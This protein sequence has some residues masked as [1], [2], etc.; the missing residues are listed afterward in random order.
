VMIIVIVDD[1][2]SCR[3]GLGGQLRSLGHEVWLA[4]EVETA[5]QIISAEKVDLVVS[6][7]RPGGR[8]WYEMLSTIDGVTPRPSIA[9]TTAYGSVA[10]AIRSMRLG[11]TAYVTK[12]LCAAT[13]LQALRMEDSVLGAEPPPHLTL[14]R[15]IWEYINSAVDGAGSIAEAARRLGVDRRSLRRML[16]KY[17]PMR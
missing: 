10:T 6:E 16:A 2:S 11:A 9:I 13:L 7:L 4:E 15:A 3:V 5:I 17:A 12:P 8:Y 1:N 14:D